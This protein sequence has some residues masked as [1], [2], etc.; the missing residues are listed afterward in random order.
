ME[1]DSGIVHYWKRGDIR[2]RGGFLE[3]LVPSKEE[4]EEDCWVGWRAG[5]EPTLRWAEND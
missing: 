1:E 2:I 3:R 4:G 5:K